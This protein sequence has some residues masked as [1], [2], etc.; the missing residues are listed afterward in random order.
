VDTRIRKLD[1]G[2]YDALVLA[3]AGLR[4]LGVASRISALLPI[5]ACVPAP[6]QGIVAVEARADDGATH[7]A[8]ADIHD[9]DAATALAGER[10]L[11]AALG[12]GCQ[13]PLGGILL[14]ESGEL[15]MRAVVL[16][17]DGTTVIRA[18]ARGPLGDP[19]GLG[20]RVAADLQA[21]GARDILNE[22]R[23]QS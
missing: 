2:G 11:V 4:R 6:G 12:G 9:R 10:A 7:A 15:E 5:D 17:P 22:A 23:R 14:R 16:A 19:E 18:Q 8:M 3:A 20:R 21:A 1:E 13:L